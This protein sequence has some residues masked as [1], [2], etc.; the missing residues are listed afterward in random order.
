VECA[1]VCG[2]FVCERVC[3][4]WVTRT[5][6]D[7]GQKIKKHTHTH[8][9]L[10]IPPDLLFLETADRALQWSAVP[11]SLDTHT[12]RG[13]QHCTSEYCSVHCPPLVSLDTLEST[14]YVSNHTLW[15]I[16][17]TMTAFFGF[18]GRMGVLLCVSALK[19]TAPRMYVAYLV[20]ALRGCSQKRTPSTKVYHPHTPPHTRSSIDGL[21]HTRFV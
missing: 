1:C 8:T 6:Q 10:E 21:T 2:G 13:T 17:G 11:R 18:F 20:W 3:D 14:R 4:H 5:N 12:A 7:K 9:H 15:E 16:T 19:P